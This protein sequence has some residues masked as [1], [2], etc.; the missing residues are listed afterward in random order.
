[1]TYLSVKQRARAGRVSGFI[2]R[3]NLDTV[4]PSSPPL[5]HIFERPVSG[6]QTSKKRS[7]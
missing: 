4:M 6:A 7:R 3:D 2:E 5:H 1:M